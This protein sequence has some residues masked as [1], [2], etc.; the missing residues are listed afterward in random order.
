MSAF[1]GSPASSD[2]YG[3]LVANPSRRVPS[4][5]W[6]S[7]L[8]MDYASYT[9]ASGSGDGEVNLL[10]LP[11]GRVRVWGALSR[12][13]VDELDT[14]A[15]VALG[16]RAYVGQDGETVVQDEDALVAATAA[17]SGGVSAA[18]DATDGVGEAE[19]YEFDSLSGVTIFATVESGD[20]D[21]D[22]KIELA[23]VYQVA[24]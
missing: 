24:N 5:E 23:L 17:D 16:Y 11:P 1:T 10:V 22:E 20:I 7:K 19:Y 13:L 18:L 14:S 2:Q 8:R 12:L 4:A 21:N 15:T 3:E 6:G 9:H